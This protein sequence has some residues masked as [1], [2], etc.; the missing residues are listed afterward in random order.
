MEW[1]DAHAT[2]FQQAL[3]KESRRIGGLRANAS[4]RRIECIVLA[5]HEVTRAAWLR[6]LALS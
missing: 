6:E 1:Q 5:C 2:H 3:G 4:R